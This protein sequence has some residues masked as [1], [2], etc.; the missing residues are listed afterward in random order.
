MGHENGLT[1]SHMQVAD[2]GCLQE[3]SHPVPF[4]SYLFSH[5][6]GPENHTAAVQFSIQHEQVQLIKTDVQI[7]SAVIFLMFNGPGIV[8]LPLA[9]NPE[10]L[11][12]V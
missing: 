7:S 6:S 9:T 8:V 4:P 2:L 10:L 5:V 3:T 12:C 1:H 11:C